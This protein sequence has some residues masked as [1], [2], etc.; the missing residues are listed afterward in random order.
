[1]EKLTTPTTINWK[2]F[3]LTRQNIPQLRLTCSWPCNERLHFV[4]QKSIDSPA[5]SLSVKCTLS[6]VTPQI[7]YSKVL[8]NLPLTQ[9]QLYYYY[10]P[11]KICFSGRIKW[12]YPNFRIAKVP[13]EIFFAI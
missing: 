12:K 2:F 11:V 7:V 10:S 8:R 9:Y 6:D 5:K 13:L 3:S 4:V 1:M